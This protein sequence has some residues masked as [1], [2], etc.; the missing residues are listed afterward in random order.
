MAKTD[1]P[2]WMKFSLAVL[3]ILGIGVGWG[4]G[5][6][7]IA[8][9]VGANTA[10]GVTLTAD[11]K[12]H[13][14]DNDEHEAAMTKRVHEMELAHQEVKNVAVQAAKSMISIDAKLGAIQAQQAKQ[15]TISAVNS[16]KLESL[17]KD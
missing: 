15:A 7:A 13:A 4:V 16:T 1:F 8:S 6:N 9:N 12:D 11:L 14:K 10:T 17:T 2:T 3:V 5:Y